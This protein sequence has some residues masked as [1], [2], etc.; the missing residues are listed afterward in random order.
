MVEVIIFG[1][2]RPFSTSFSSCRNP[3]CHG[4]S[5]KRATSTS[6]WLPFMTILFGKKHPKR[7]RGAKLFASS[8]P[9]SSANKDLGFLFQ[10]RW[11]PCFTAH[12][13][14]FQK[15]KG[16]PPGF[17]NSANLYAL[18]SVSTEKVKGNKKGGDSLNTVKYLP[19]KH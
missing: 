10:G 6:L 4:G 3:F 19:Q 8:T 7:G 9:T 12:H 1:V 5:N 11:S 14:P 2:S 17:V 15:K 18:G 16:A 13:P